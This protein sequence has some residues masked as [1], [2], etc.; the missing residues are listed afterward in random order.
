MLMSP[1]ELNTLFRERLDTLGLP[2]ELYMRILARHCKADYLERL[3]SEFLWTGADPVAFMDRLFSM[4][5]TKISSG[6]LSY[7]ES[8]DLRST[9]YEATAA[10][11]A[12]KSGL[13]DG[14]ILVVTVVGDTRRDYYYACAKGSEEQVRSLYTKFSDRRQRKDGADTRVEDFFFSHLVLGQG[15]CAKG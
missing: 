14:K 10:R 12:I 9:L 2:D 3:A 8:F 11:F 13:N 1:N 5:R 7:F 15:A 6:N 4:L